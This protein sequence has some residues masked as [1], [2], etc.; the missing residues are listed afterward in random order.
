MLYIVFLS[1]FKFGVEYRYYNDNMQELFC[2]FF[3]F[4]DIIR[5]FCT[6]VYREAFTDTIFER[7]KVAK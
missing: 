6:G 3:M 5:I 1:M 7:S 2:V 4:M